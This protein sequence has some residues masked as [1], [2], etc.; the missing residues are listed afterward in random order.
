MDDV[1]YLLAFSFR[2]QN[3]QKGVSLAELASGGN[4]GPHMAAI[5]KNP[6]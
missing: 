2:A 3:L 4:A 1:N 5:A 6:C